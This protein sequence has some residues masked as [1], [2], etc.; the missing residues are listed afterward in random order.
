MFR[1]HRTVRPT[2]ADAGRSSPRGAGRQRDQLAYAFLGDDDEVEARLSYGELDGKARAIGALLQSSGACGERVLLLY[3]PGLDFIVAFFGCLYAGA[4]AVPAYPPRPNRPLDR[5]RSIVSDSQAEWMLTTARLMASVQRSFAAEPDLQGLRWFTTDNLDT[6]ALPTW[7]DVGA[8]P[9][10]IALLQYTSGSTGAPKGVI[11]SHAN[12]WHN[13]RMMHSGF[14][15]MAES[16]AVGWLPLYHDM[17]LIGLVVQALFGGVCSYLLSPVAFLQR[18]VRWLR[19]IT[20]YRAS[21]SGAPNFAYD[22]CC[23]KV[24]REQRA[25]LDL[26]SWRV[27]INGSEPVRTET[28]DRFAVEFA[29]CGFRREAFY[30]CYGMAE[31]TLFVSGGLP[32]KPPV[33]RT[34][35]SAALEA[36]RVVARRPGEPARAAWW[37]AAAPGAVNGYGSLTLI[38]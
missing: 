34:V 9:G 6:T 8:G 31:A 14:G 11:V 25:E 16:T 38:V 24:T 17:G 15:H 5:I 7:Q 18:P 22:L 3:P 36:N 37:A 26:S 29:A 23:R 28:L 10:T 20:R 12:L 4:V 2:S 30:P 32:A 13:A 19:A 27:A 21:A 1:K 33:I 35:D